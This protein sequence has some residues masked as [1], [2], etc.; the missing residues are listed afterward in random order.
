M[1][2]EQLRYQ[3]DLN[4]DFTYQADEETQPEQAPVTETG[5]D[6]LKPL[7]SNWKTFTFRIRVNLGTTNNPA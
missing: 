1:T 2:D 5:K 3:F 4:V 7:G 6:R